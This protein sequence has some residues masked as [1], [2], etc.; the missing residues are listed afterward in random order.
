L[1]AQPRAPNN[2]MLRPEK[3]KRQVHTTQDSGEA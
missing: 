2:R 3:M 1:P